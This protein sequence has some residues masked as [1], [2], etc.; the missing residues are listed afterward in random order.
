MARLFSLLFFI[1]PF[2]F[3]P[4]TSEIFEI[5]TLT[6]L[7][8]FTAISLMAASFYA[9]KKRKPILISYNLYTLSAVAFTLTTALAA[10]FSI[11]QKTSVWG[12]YSRFNGGLLSIATYT[13]LVIIY[14]NVSS[15]KTVNK[16][17]SILIYTA[18]G[19]AILAVLEHF[20]LSATCLI[21]SQ[22]TD[23]SCWSQDVASRVFATFG[24]PNWLAAY[25]AAILPLSWAYYLKNK[26]HKHLFISLLVFIAIIFSRSRSGL[27]AV[28]LTF[29]VFS[30]FTYLNGKGTHMRKLLAIFTIFLTTYFV[31]KPDLVAQKGAYINI[32]PSSQIRF[33]VWR[34]AW[35]SFTHNPILGTGPETFAFS[36]WK[37]RPV[38]H[39]L[40]SEWD[41]TYNKAHNDF[42]HILSTQG[43]VGF[44]AYMWVAAAGLFF[45]W[46]KKNKH[47]YTKLALFCGYIGLLVSQFFGFL[48]VNTMLLFFVYPVFGGII[49]KRKLKQK[50]ISKF[51][52][53]LTIFLSTLFCFYI[54]RF[55]LADISYKN[56]N[57]NKQNKLLFAYKLHPE[58]LYLIKLADYRFQS[59]QVKDAMYLANLA[60]NQA[61][62]NTKVLEMA[63]DLFLQMGELDENYTDAENLNNR[64][65]FLMPTNAKLYYQK[66]FILAQKGKKEEATSALEEAIDLKA[67]YEKARILLGFILDELGLHDQAK[68]QY[69]Y[70][71]KNINPDNDMSRQKLNSK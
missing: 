7:Y 44:L 6:F 57:V 30:F 1:L 14:Q 8:L 34:G 63:L 41:Y 13:T 18:L 22:K 3:F 12:Y 19:L 29:L 58:P 68:F 59:G 60:I 39:N 4:Y 37:H 2:L 52:F 48:T 31:T 56:A 40:T 33:L 25:L 61:P 26:G 35:Q 50:T 16:H 38:A 62:S 51:V 64:L 46:P 47:F 45:L 36:Y 55:Y 5:N 15:F 69:E 54:L 43:I 17:L 24:Q 67:N 21:L 20:N 70:V 11:D 66:G 10:Y 27:L 32:T 53:F 65:I 49:Q 9:L 71:L 42:L 23:N 28:I